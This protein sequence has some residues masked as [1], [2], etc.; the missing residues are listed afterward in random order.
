MS[1][2]NLSK[3]RSAAALFEALKQENLDEI[4]A[5]SFSKELKD[6]STQTDQV[7]PTA[8][9]NNID[10]KLN[11]MLALLAHANAK[12]DVIGSTGSAEHEHKCEA[13]ALRKINLQPVKNLNDLES[14]EAN[15]KSEDFV[16]ASVA[17][18]GQLH[19][20]QRYTT[21]GGTVCLQIID[22][23]FDRQF[24]VQCS[25]TGTGRKH[26]ED[27][28]IPKKIPFSRYE[29]VINLFYQTVLHSDP[30][31]SFDECKD[32]LHRCLRNAKQRLEELGGTRKPVA[33]KRRQLLDANCQDVE[34]LDD[35]D[36]GEATEMVLEI[37]ADDC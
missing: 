5:V 1:R 21:R 7:A 11:K 12:L 35:L 27:N 14:L 18:I 17:S 30:E 19:G 25:W 22:Y 29:K 10:V 8:E 34:Y 23:F 32:F 3:K 6:S 13:V 15:C 36:Q 20:R 37:A 33:R 4:A 2:K 26:I 28:Q 9:T 31:F 24:L 16:K